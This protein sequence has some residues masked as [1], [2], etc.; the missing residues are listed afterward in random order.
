[1]AR[2]VLASGKKILPY[3]GLWV[4]WCSEGR[5]WETFRVGGASGGISTTGA[6]GAVGDDAGR[7]FESVV[8][9]RDACGGLSTT[10]PVPPGRAPHAFGG[11][12]PG[13]R[14]V[15]EATRAMGSGGT[16]TI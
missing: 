12:G 4:A 15:G 14:G 5:C 10:E 1:M 11:G 8:S 7:L 3:D 13:R 9:P 16:S 6:R 2:E